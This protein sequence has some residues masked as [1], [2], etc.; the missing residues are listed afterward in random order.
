MM[1]AQPKEELV[2]AVR[3]MFAYMRKYTDVP[4]PPKSEL[5]LTR[6]NLDIVATFLHSALA[7]CQ[8]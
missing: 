6:L 2:A 4:V 8:K 1:K 3:A 7:K 5:D